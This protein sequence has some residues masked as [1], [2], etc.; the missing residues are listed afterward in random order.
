MRFPLVL[1]LVALSL[2]GEACGHISGGGDCSGGTLDGD[3][4]VNT[5]PSVHWTA[6]RASAAADR[7]IYAP[8]VR[9]KLTNA[10]C[11]IVARYAGN[12]AKAVC[13][14]VFTPPSDAPRPVRLAFSLSGIGIVNPDC[15]THWATSPYC[16]ARGRQPTSGDS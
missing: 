9:G 3:T 1:V 7:F 6:A 2:F 15:N 13:S 5:Q 8:M 12:E 10:H 16:T 4:C 11:R 14:A